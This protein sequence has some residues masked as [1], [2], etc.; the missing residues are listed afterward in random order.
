VL[1]VILVFLA[2]LARD[3]GAATTCPSPI[4]GAF[5]AMAALGFTINLS[6]LFA[7]V[8]RSASWWTTPSSWS[9]A[10]RTISSRACSSHDARD[11]GDGPVVRA[12]HRHH[13]GADLGVPAGRRSCLVWT[14]RIYAQFALVI[15]A[16]AL[17]SASMPDLEADAMPLWLRHLLRAENRPPARW[18]RATGIRRCRSRAAC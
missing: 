15:A 12:D 14:G 17:L 5:A 1:V 16:T 13:A 8:L 7:I 6:T 2:G 18:R 11:Q 3:A 9:K 4:I 10:P